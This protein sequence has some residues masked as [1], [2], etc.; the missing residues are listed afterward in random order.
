M[1][2][3]L[4]LVLVLSIISQGQN[5]LK[6]ADEEDS[7]GHLP[8]RS[9]L[10]EDDDHRRQNCKAGLA[11]IQNDFS[12]YGICKKKSKSLTPFYHHS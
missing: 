11:C 6:P 1:N 10:Q 8:I 2:S 9:D 5:F 12:C 7:C 4:F 3:I